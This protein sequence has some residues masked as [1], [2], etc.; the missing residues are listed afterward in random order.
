MLLTLQRNIYSWRFGGRLELLGFFFFL[1]PFWGVSFFF[2]AGS[3]FVCF[4][5]VCI[6][7]QSSCAYEVWEPWQNLL[8]QTQCKC[9]DRN[10]S[11]IRTYF[12]EYQQHMASGLQKSS[13]QNLGC[14]VMR[15]CN[16]MAYDYF[17]SSCCKISYQKVKFWNLSGSNAT[18]SY[19]ILIDISCSA[20]LSLVLSCPLILLRDQVA[21]MSPLISQGLCR[22][23]LLCASSAKKASHRTWD[24]VSFDITL[25]LCIPPRGCYKQSP[26]GSKHFYYWI[27]ALQYHSSWNFLYRKAVF[28]CF[29]QK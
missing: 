8:L 21:G 25:F 7:I 19:H 29:Y 9:F 24:V 23:V 14:S 11:K 3:L 26:M 12:S 13:A 10:L 17:Y 28:L 16:K 22:G 15:Q 6:G 1:F 5:C 2:L 4:L 27:P 18:L 20:L